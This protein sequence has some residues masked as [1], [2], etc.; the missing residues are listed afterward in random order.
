MPRSKKVSPR[1]R[2][3]TEAGAVINEA[4]LDAASDVL[5]KFGV[6]GVT[7]N[8][9]AKRAGVSIG[10]L[11]QYYPNK[12][13]IL[14][15]LTRRMERRTQQAIAAVLAS[16]RD[17]PLVELAAGV[18]DVMLGEPLGPISVRRALRT[19]VPADWTMSTSSDVDENVRA[20]VAEELGR[21]SDVRKGDR[22]A[23]AFIAS[24]AVEMVVESAVLGGPQLLEAPAFRDELVTLV[25][26]YLSEEPTR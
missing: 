6:N 20:L 18:V 25:V 3:S 19:V 11:Y 2:P 17:K 9:V 14:A 13:A 4:I 26:R 7:T 12:E 10:S 15:E 22:V 24:H 16:Y 5:E 21:R 8:R 1:K 23:M